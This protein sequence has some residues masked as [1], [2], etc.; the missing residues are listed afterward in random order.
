MKHGTHRTVIFPR[1]FITCVVFGYQE[2]GKKK[3]KNPCCLISATLT[4]KQEEKKQDLTH[5]FGIL[6]G[7][8]PSM[9]VGMGFI[10]LIS[11]C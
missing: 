3:N 2:R 7:F 1:I 10:I 11:P 8:V 4:K 5:E 6:S 9:I